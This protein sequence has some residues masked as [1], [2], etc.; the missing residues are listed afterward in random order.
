MAVSPC[1][2]STCPCI[3]L[4]STG[5]VIG[6]RQLG[7]AVKRKR[8]NSRVSAPKRSRKV[9]TF[10]LKVTENLVIRH[11]KTEEHIKNNSFSLV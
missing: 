5:P 9:A 2:E 7:V 1:A 4:P 3:H 10:K 8:T 11:L 6:Y